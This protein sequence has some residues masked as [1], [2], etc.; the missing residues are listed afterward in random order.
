MLPLDDCVMASLLTKPLLPDEGM[1]YAGVPLF[2][3][4]TKQE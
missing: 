1:E 2:T 3:Q 4:Q